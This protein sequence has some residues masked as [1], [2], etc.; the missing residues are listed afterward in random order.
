MLVQGVC[1]SLKN[2]A[3]NEKTNRLPKPAASLG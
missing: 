2:F 1:I 3:Q